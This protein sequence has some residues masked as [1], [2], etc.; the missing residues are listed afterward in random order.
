L[1]DS[2][3]GE[4]CPAQFGAGYTQTLMARLKD[5]STWKVSA[6]T[7][8]PNKTI[9]NHTHDW[10]KTARPTGFAHLNEQFKAYPGWQFCLTANAHGRVHG[11]LI[12]DTFHVVWLDQ[13]HALYPEK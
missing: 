8:L 10:A 7:G 11:I 5:L 3:D 1:F 4:M 9:R 2:T 6:F 13:D 12:D